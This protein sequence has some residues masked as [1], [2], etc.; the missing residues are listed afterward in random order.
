MGAKMGFLLHLNEM[1]VL[2]LKIQ[3][4]FLYLSMLFLM[5]SIFRGQPSSNIYQ[6]N[7][8][9]I[10]NKPFNFDTLRGKK[11]LIVN[12]ASECGFTPQ[13]KQLEEIYKKYKEKNFVIVGFPTNNFGGQEPGKN[14]EIKSFCE[15]N[16]GVTFLMME[17][18]SVKGNDMHPI[19]KWLTQK[20]ENGVMNS[21]VKWNFQKYLINEKGELEGVLAPWKKPNSRR[22]VKWVEG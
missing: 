8:N 10:E 6:F 22:I 3:I 4:N 5:S 14:D 17:K 7:C 18:I 1:K 9:T 20:A 13:F 11:I 19:Y 21:S 16:Y 2:I 12:T 15:R